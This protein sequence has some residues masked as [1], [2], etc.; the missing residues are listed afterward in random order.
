MPTGDTLITELTLSQAKLIFLDVLQPFI[1][2][3]FALLII[4]TIYFAYKLIIYPF[5]RKI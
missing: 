2:I 3:F 4:L 1:E 5:F